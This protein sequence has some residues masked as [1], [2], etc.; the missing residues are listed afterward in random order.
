VRN[1]PI[2]E[3][4]YYDISSFN[5]L[6]D[7]ELT[8]IAGLTSAAD[9]GIYFTGSGAAALFDLSSFSRTLLDD[10]T[11]GAA[12]T[13]L[14]VGTADTPAFAQV[15][16][17]GDPSTALQAATK[18][19]VDNVAQGLDVKPSARAATTANI[20]RSGTQTVDGVALVANDRCLVKN[21][22]APAENGIFSVQA[23]AWTR[24]TDMDAWS[25]VPGAFVFIE[26]GSTLADTGWVCTANAG[27]TLNTTAITW[28]QFSGV[29]AYQPLDAEL[30]AIAGLTS[31]ADKGIY[32]TGS[33]TAAVFDLSSFART[34]LD[35]A[36]APVARTTLNVESLTNHGDSIY[37]ILSTDR[38]VGTNAAFTASRTWTLPAANALN[39]GQALLIVD[40]QGTVTAANTL[41][42]ARAGSDTIRGAATSYTLNTAHAA[43]LFISDGVSKWEVINL[44]LA[45]AAPAAIGAA[46]AVG[47]SLNAA[48]EDHVHQYALEAIQIAASDETTALSA[49]VGKMTFRMPYAFTVTDV[50]ASLTTAQATGAIFTVDVNEAGTTILST[51]LTI[52]NT[53]KTTQTAATARVIS[54]TALADDA[55]ITIDIDQIGDGTAKG[56]KV[57]LIGR[58]S[59]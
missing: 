21:Q 49:G 30:T 50:R 23:G 7:A 3:L 40:F 29:G 39:P 10:T 13:T 16:L 27:G 52:D 41:V 46:A 59:A 44:N 4:Q 28:S 12:R 47:T 36:S 53:E 54:D 14:G 55:E 58:K 26:E 9:K 11:Q 18:Q 34:V 6:T 17:G 25:E 43:A 48:R 33:G 15:A 38:V 45:T 5:N 19:Y 57:T 1:V 20:T 31:A 32:F 51:K 2:G 42:I 56:L 24:V 35:D 22:T 8:A 37:T